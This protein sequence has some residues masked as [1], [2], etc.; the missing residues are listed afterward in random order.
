MVET[1]RFLKQERRLVDARVLWD[2]FRSPLGGRLKRAEEEGRLHKEQQFMIGIRAR[3][4]ELADSDELVLV[5]GVIDA[6]IEEAE[7]SVLIDYKT[8]RVK[9]AEEL[10]KRYQVQLFYYIRAL[11]QVT[12]KPVKEA[13]LYSLHLQEEIRI[14]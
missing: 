7:G 14:L 8:D 1:G 6:Y 3:E 10:K 11:E 5:Q 13:L 12:G 2:F 9:E 4:M